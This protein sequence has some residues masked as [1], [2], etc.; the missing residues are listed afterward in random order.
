MKQR[1]RV[2]QAN[3]DLERC[4]CANA[5]ASKVGSDP[6]FYKY[7]FLS[8]VM[9]LLLLFTFNVLGTNRGPTDRIQHI[10]KHSMFKAFDNRAPKK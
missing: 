2:M 7:M 10:K 5:P 3:I 8:S 9:L 6:R 1:T 4:Y